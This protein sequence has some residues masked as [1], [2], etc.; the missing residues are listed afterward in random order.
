MCRLVAYKGAPILMDQLLYQPQNSLIHQSYHALERN[1]PVNGD[2]FGVGWY[3]P[4]IS[5]EPARYLSVRPAWNDNNL[6]SLAGITR[7][8]CICAHVRDASVGIVSEINCHPFKYKNLLMMHNGN[9]G[10]FKYIKR[11]LRSLLASEIYDWIKGETDSEHFFA[12]FL[13]YLQNK[14]EG[15]YKAEDV[16]EAIRQAITELKNIFK[17]NKIDD[18]F[19]LNLIIGNGK[20]LVACRYDTNKNVES[21]TLYH[22]SSDGRFECINGVCKVRSAEADHRGVLIVSEKLT[23]VEEDWHKIPEA[24]FIVVTENLEISVFPVFA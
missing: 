16:V 11:K 19:F 4:G 14:A 12:L 5:P 17:A 3:V 22:S 18:D 24:H 13:N 20:W 8:N 9:I 7:S 15:D 21:P 2:G 10:H 6:R 1:D 23:D